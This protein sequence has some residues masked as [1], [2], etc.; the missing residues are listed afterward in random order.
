MPTESHIA[1][2]HKANIH[3]PNTSNAAKHHSKEV[4]ENEFNVK[5]NDDIDKKPVN[6]ASGLKAAIHNP[7]VSEEAKQSAKERLEKDF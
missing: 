2:G 7:N 5:V 3:N 1:A 4:L 6:V